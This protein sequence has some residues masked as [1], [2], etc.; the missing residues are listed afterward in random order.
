MFMSEIDY[1]PDYYANVNLSHGSSSQSNLPND[2]WLHNYIYK[3][4]EWR[5]NRIINPHAYAGTAVQD[6]VNYY[7]FNSGNDDVPVKAAI[8]LALKNFKKS[9]IFFTSASYKEL[10]EMDLELIPQCVENALSGLTEMEFFKHS[11]TE[12][13]TEDYCYYTLPGIEITTIGRTDLLTD[14]FAV[15]LKTKWKSRAK[16]ENKDGSAKWRRNSIP[17]NPS[18]EHLRQ[19]AFYY[20]ATKREVFLV[21]AAGFDD[22]SYKVF[23]KDNCE[24]LR[25]E[26]LEHYLDQMQMIQKVRQNLLQISSNPK[27]LAKYIPP[28]FTHYMWRDL[29]EEE[30]EE[31]R[32]LWR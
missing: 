22:K 31:A 10:W 27:T 15:E 13:T 21:Y 11:T 14:K 30:L 23:S 28:D 20:K 5:Q 6:G 25:P 3:N 32:N 12:K 7:I 1:I 24:K 16:G 29:T 2:V 26:F 18:I 8:K 4:A 17:S 19:C 9:K